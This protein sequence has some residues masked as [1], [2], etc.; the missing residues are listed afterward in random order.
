MSEFV[1]KIDDYKFRLLYKLYLYNDNYDV[2][3]KRKVTVFKKG[4]ETELVCDCYVKIE[5]SSDSENSTELNGIS[6]WVYQSKSEL[7]LW[8]FC[9]C[10][11]AREKYKGPDY[12]QSTLIHLDLQNYININLSE[13]QYDKTE[14]D[15]AE[16][17]KRN[18][19]KYATELNNLNLKLISQYGFNCPTGEFYKINEISIKDII[20]SKERM[21]VLEPF[22]KFDNDD[23]LRC[24]YVS[25]HYNIKHK[26]RTFSDE[27]KYLYDPGETEIVIENYSDIFQDIIRVSGQIKRILL[28]N[29]ETGVQVYLYFLE[30]TLC[31]IG[32]TPGVYDE[33]I[34][35]ICNIDKHYMP[36]LLTPID[37]KCNFMGIYDKYIP[38]GIYICKLFDYS[39]KSNAP[40]LKNNIVQ[41]TEQ[42]QSFGQCNETYSY[43]GSRYEGLFPFDDKPASSFSFF[44]PVN[45]WLWSGGKSRKTSKKRKNKKMTRRKPIRIIPRSALRI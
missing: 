15:T 12:I 5:S 29:K 38:A 9:T 13:L 4:K 8:R 23:E 20:D 18:D 36:F 7:G 39:K 37:S 33:N 35:R 3:D 14:V 11:S 41:C 17:P 10:Q 1:I 16:R 25:Q 22:N 32:E 21:V 43:I 26:L 6:F 40:F 31:K 45:W 44:W 24:G 19:I 2:S 34:E 30:A 27:I 42:E 28:T